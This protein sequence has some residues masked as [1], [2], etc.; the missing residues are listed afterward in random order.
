MTLLST[1]SDTLMA[2]IT[3]EKPLF[4]S[5]D[6]VV[7]NCSVEQGGPADSISWFKGDKTPFRKGV[8]VMSKSQDLSRLLLTNVSLADRGVYGCLAKKGAVKNED[9][10][11]LVVRG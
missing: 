6:N 9:S 11:T 3:P 4:N 5:G 1:G 10:Y 2:F 8:H 7:L